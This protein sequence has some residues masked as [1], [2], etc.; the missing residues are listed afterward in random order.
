MG[1]SGESVSVEE[2]TSAS[3]CILMIYAGEFPILLS[4]L[5]VT[6]RSQDVTATGWCGVINYNRVALCMAIDYCK[7][8]DA[9]K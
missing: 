6:V 7:H 3:I 1:V 4:D 2:G 5:I 8:S 9:Q